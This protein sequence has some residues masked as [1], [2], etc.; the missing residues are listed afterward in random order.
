MGHARRDLGPV[1][2]DGAH[3]CRPATTAHD[4][5]YRDF[6]A[7]FPLLRRRAT[8]V[9]AEAAELWTPFGAAPACAWLERGDPG[10]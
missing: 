7:G 1:V 9:I 8:L 3:R 2:A 6:Q 10:P 4:D 5:C